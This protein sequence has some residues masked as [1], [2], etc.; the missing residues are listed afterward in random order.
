MLGVDSVRQHRQ[1]RFEKISGDL[2]GHLAIQPC[3]DKLWRSDPP[4]QAGRPGLAGADLTDDDRQVADRIAL[5]RLLLARLVAI[6]RQLANPVPLIKAVQA[7]SG[8]R[9]DFPLKGMETIIEQ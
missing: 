2:P 1:R 6:S 8:Q 4:R 3:M 9:G 5:E 7:R